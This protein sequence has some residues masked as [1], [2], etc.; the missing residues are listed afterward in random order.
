MCL[1]CICGYR[2]P[3][4]KGVRFLESRQ[5]PPLNPLIHHENKRTG[6]LPETDRSPE[7]GLGQVQSE[8]K[9]LN[10]DLGRERKEN[11]FL[12]FGFL[13]QCLNVSPEIYLA[14]DHVSPPLLLSP[15]REQRTRGTV[16]EPFHSRFSRLATLSSQSEM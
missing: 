8:E 10:A 12:G 1:V 16:S 5:S 3:G 13:A 7:S 4:Q 15:A 6:E 11:P 14:R 2:S 9:G